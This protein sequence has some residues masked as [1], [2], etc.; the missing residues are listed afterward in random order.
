MPVSLTRSGV[1]PAL[2]RTPSQ[3][4]A[5][6]SPAGA[7]ASVEAYG[8]TSLNDAVFQALVRRPDE[9]HRALLV[10]F[11]DGRDTASWLGADAIL[12][13]ARRGDAVVFAVSR[14]PSWDSAVRGLEGRKILEVRERAR[15]WF[16]LE[17]RLI[18]GLMLSQLAEETGGG[19]YYTGEDRD[20]RKLFAEVV[21]AFKSGYLLSYVPQSVPADG[22]HPIEVKLKGARGDVTARRG[23]QR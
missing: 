21:A 20:L 1:P 4:N 17:P 18:R 9:E 3:S 19:Q 7:V 22:W 15:K 2:A 5:S 8:W 13:D 10:V 23:Y 6:L 11:S 12:E 14:R 16:T